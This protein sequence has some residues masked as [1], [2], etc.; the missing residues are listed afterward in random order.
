M[1]FRIPDAPGRLLL[2]RT[3][4]DERQLR[5][6]LK[7]DDGFRAANSP[8]WPSRCDPLLPV[9][10]GGS[11]SWRGRSAHSHARARARVARASCIGSLVPR[12]VIVPYSPGRYL[13][14]Q[15]G[16]A[17]RYLIRQ[18]LQALCVLEVPN[19]PDMPKV[20]RDI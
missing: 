8:A 17:L 7:I 20:K 2:A 9:R 4:D 10:R 3:T 15:S 18:F 11:G 1:I 16:K 5:S 14:R 12:R 6:T 19:V 13:L